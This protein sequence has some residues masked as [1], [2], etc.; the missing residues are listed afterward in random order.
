MSYNIT[1]DV[2]EDGTVTVDESISYTVTAPKGRYVVSGHDV[3]SGEKGT[4]YVQIMIPEQALQATAT[5][6]V[7]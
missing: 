5:R 4:E 2:S 3:S 1:F 7:K 6:A